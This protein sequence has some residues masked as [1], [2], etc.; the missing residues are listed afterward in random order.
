MKLIALD[1]LKEELSREESK[2][3]SD[4]N[5]IELLKDAIRELE[6]LTSK[7]D[8]SNC[9][10]DIPLE[11]LRKLSDEDALEMYKRCSNCSN[12]H[13]SLFESK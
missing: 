3:Y 4:S 7:L 11:E 6:D 10:Y 9:K 1:L 2:L 8:C 13:E 5:R 12:Y